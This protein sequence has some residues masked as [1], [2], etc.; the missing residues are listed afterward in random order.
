MQ[1]A[2]ASPFDKTIK[3]KAWRITPPAFEDFAEFEAWAERAL[4]ADAV[5][6]MKPEIAM[7]AC[8][9][10]TAAIGAMLDTRRGALR[11]AWIVL[12]R[13]RPDLTESA[14]LAEGLEFK[15]L[16]EINTEAIQASM[17]ETSKAEGEQGEPFRA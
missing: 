6:V 11:F 17:P 16:D 4:L 13:A 5:A 2:A 8:L 12:R 9:R 15:D 10:G 1:K 7:Q 3:G 14:M